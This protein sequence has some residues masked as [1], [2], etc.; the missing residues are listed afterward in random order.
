M[1]IYK[2]II[3]RLN[4]IIYLMLFFNRHF[5][6]EYSLVENRISTRAYGNLKREYRVLGCANKIPGILF[7]SFKL[8]AKLSTALVSFSEI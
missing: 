8:I 5:C 1:H 4:M 6:S 3:S 7:S 2:Q